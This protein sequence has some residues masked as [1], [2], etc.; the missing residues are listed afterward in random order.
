MPYG[1]RIHETGGPEVL[2]WEEVEVGKPGP[3][4]VLVRNTA[5]GVNFID[6]Y[7]RTGLYP[8]NLPATLGMEGAGVVEAVGPRVTEFK[9]GDRV[10]Y[11]QPIGSY[12]ELAL[13][14]A[15]RLVKIPAGVDDRI[16]AAMMLKGMTAQYLLRRTYRVKAGDTIL[17]HAAA[18]GVGQILCQW[19]KHLGATVIGTVGSDEK[20]KLA[21]KAGCRHVIVSSREKIPERV[22]EITRGKGV[23]VVYDGIGKDTFTDSLDCLAPLGLMVSYGNASGAVP[24]INIGI[25]SQKGSLFLT[26]P[27]LMTYVAKRED[28]VKSARELF[29]VVKKGAVKIAVNQTYPL[30]E[31][32]QAHRDL[33]ARKTTGSTVLLP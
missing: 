8:V 19:G 4:Q 22:K 2:R 11:A 17:V 13:R 10:A 23:P 26:R 1:I 29:A 32:A 12:A 16:A 27:T 15:E 14:P 3:G 7:H 18:G 28:L 33:E 24:P 30:R 25:L 31:A 21:K 9:P 5:V 6:T 20:A